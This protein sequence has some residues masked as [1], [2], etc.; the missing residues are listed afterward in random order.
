MKKQRQQQKNINIKKNLLTKMSA[1]QSWTI[2]KFQS[3]YF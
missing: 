1:V 2:K 3:N